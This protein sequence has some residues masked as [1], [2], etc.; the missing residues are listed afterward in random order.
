[1][2]ATLPRNPQKMKMHHL[3]TD[4]ITLFEEYAGGIR[5]IWS[6]SDKDVRLNLNPHY[7]DED[8]SEG[9][10]HDIFGSEGEYHYVYSDRFS[11]RSFLQYCLDRAVQ[12]GRIAGSAGM[13]ESGLTYYYGGPVTLHNI[14]AGVNRSSGYSYQ[15][16][17]FECDTWRNEELAAAWDQE[18][19]HNTEKL[20]VMEELLHA[21][22]LENVS[23]TFHQAK[24]INHRDEIA[25][26]EKRLA[27]VKGLLAATEAESPIMEIHA[28]EARIKIEELLKDQAF[29]FPVLR[30]HRK[31]Y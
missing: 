14:K 7:T 4:G 31:H 29:T 28:E 20:R 12:D 3:C 9:Q 18:R 24:L 2:N 17:G 19:L 1:M 23:T 16:F 25:R 26:L 8:Y 13:W 11:N 30:N 27:E 10:V 21:Q 6:T 5:R 22:Q 15:V